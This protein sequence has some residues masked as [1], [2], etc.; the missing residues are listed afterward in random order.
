MKCGQDNFWGH[1]RS[2]VVMAT[3]SLPFTC[4]ILVAY[5]SIHFLGQEAKKTIFLNFD[6]FKHFIL[7]SKSDHEHD[8]CDHKYPKV[9]FC[10]CGILKHTLFGSGTSKKT[11]L[12]HFDHFKHNMWSSS[13][14][15]E[16]QICGHK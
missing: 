14:G 16:H 3:S 9:L 11:E 7:S 8:K 15:H 10:T 2:F 5:H 4:Y 12:F 6:H 13:S 1:F